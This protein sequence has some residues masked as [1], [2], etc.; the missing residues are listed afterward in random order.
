MP[1]QFITLLRTLMEQRK[2]SQPKLANVSGVPRETIRSWFKRDS[3]PR[4]WEPVI[5]IAAALKV[6]RKTA[7]QLLNAAGHPALTTL[8]YIAISEIDNARLAADEFRIYHYQTLK[9]AIEQWLQA[10]SAN[11]PQVTDEQE[12]K[13]DTISLSPSVQIVQGELPGRQ[14][15]FFGREGEVAQLEEWLIQDQAQLLA[16]IGNGG[17]GKTTL[18]AEVVHNLAKTKTNQSSS[19][20]SSST[21]PA[22]N[23]DQIIW[24]SLVNSPPLETVLNRW[25]QSISPAGY[26][27]SSVSLDEQLDLLFDY[28]QQHRC[29]LVLDNFESILAS[30][31][32]VGTYRSGYEAYSQLLHRF[33]NTQHQSCLLITSRET[34]LEITRLGRAFGAVKTLPVGGLSYNS[35]ADLLRNLGIAGGADVDT[36]SHRIESLVERYSGN[37]LGLKLVAET[38]NDL[39][40]G[41]IENFLTDETVIFDDIY[42]VI[43]QQ[44]N[45]L[46]DIEQAILIWLTVEREPIT[47]KT[48]QKNLLRTSSGRKLREALLSLI[49]RSIIEVHTGEAQQQNSAKN[50]RGDEGRF[51]LQNVIMEYMTEKIVQTAATEL[52]DGPMDFVMQYALI[53]S[54]SHTYV[55]EAQHRLLLE[56]IA[57]QILSQIGQ[58]N[59]MNWASERLSTLRMTAGKSPGYA[60]GIL[61]NILIHFQNSNYPVDLSQLD[62]SGLALW[63]ALLYD[64]ELQNINLAQCDLSHAKFTDTFSSIW[65]LGYTPDGAF[66]IAGT[67]N[68]AVRIWRSSELQIIAELHGHS[69]PVRSVAVSANGCILATGSEDGTVRVWDLS[70]LKSNETSLPDTLDIACIQI[71]DHHTTPISKVVIAPDNQTLAAAS[72][73]GLIH[74]WTTESSTTFELSQQLQGHEGRVRGIS[75]DPQQEVIASCGDDGTVRLWDLRTTKCILTQ[76]AHDSYVYAVAI[77]AD[78]LHLAS[79]GADKMVH[80][81]EIEKSPATDASDAEDRLVTLNNQ[82]TVA[83]HTLPVHNLA[84]SP[85]SSRLATCAEDGLILLSDLADSASRK[86]I[87]GHAGWIRGLAFSPD[88]HMIA[89]AG[90]DVTLRLWDVESGENISNLHGFS[91]SITSASLSPDEKQLVTGDYVVRL[92]ELADD[93]SPMILA[94]HESFI[95]QVLY[96]QN[97]QWI[98]SASNDACVRLWDPHTGKS[99]Y[100][101]Q[102]E[103]AVYS[104]AFGQ[105]DQFLA[106][107]ENRGQVKLWDVN[108]GQLLHTWADATDIIWGLDFCSQSPS[109]AAGCE[110]GKIYIWNLQSYELERV[111]HTHSPV[112][113]VAISPVQQ[114]LA[115]GDRDK[116]IT[117]WNCQNGEQI[118][119]LQA[120]TDLVGSLRFSADGQTLISSSFDGSVCL[121]SVDSHQL[122][123]KLPVHNGAIRSIHFAPKSTSLVSGSNDGTVKI[124]EIGHIINEQKEDDSALRNIRQLRVPGPYA[125]MDIS[126]V[127][128]ITPTQQKALIALGATTIRHGS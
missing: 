112:R 33:G 125:G 6:D 89:S 32:Q 98:A 59:L 96:S 105:H 87:H 116:T 13:S 93:K 78:G 3:S 31:E 72:H 110:D 2:L 8:Q 30:G 18:A 121:W 15:V 66:L 51:F 16:I 94:G 97:G 118:A 115:C 88:G 49:R 4:E 81:W 57:E 77:S 61:L 21:S 99:V 35:G 40:A 90:V 64:Q 73:D 83:G 120:H 23:F 91:I 113:A 71:L 17:I 42:E 85:D 70:N 48:L 68:G 56:P 104:I 106:S 46:S 29:L 100:K 79:C 58:A 24:R 62:F 101:L 45:R 50:S 10:K 55:I 102:A 67:T 74:L 60:G 54:Q 12:T 80:I 25:L 28:F 65:S 27:N 92:W 36:S 7:A 37:P 122:I 14:N 52:I 107:G 43:D 123:K 111:I 127:T 63:H 128:G 124:Y 95:W 82:Q 76:S 26:T 109:I 9:E 11:S 39:Y 47:T 119:T 75:F 84:F 1:N 108:T 86:S 69:G 22:S 38:V 44:Y 117:L 103:R 34:P 114:L 20:Q 19:T 41:N 126:G 53:K 5:Q